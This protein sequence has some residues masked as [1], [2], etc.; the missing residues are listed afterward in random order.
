MNA[1]SS[2]FSVR[3]PRSASSRP[4]LPPRTTRSA[5]PPGGP[6]GSSPAVRLVFG[7]RSQHH[8]R[9]LPCMSK[10]P[11][12]LAHFCP[13]GWVYHPSYHDT[14]HIRP[15]RRIIRQTCNDPLL[16]GRDRQ[17][18]TPP[19][20]ADDTRAPSIRTR[21][22]SRL[23]L[24]ERLQSFLLAQVV[25]KRHRVQPRNAIHRKLGG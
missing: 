3:R 14:R 16:F 6:C 23:E 1:G 19:R 21:H 7:G 8:S 13:T 20:S 10:S 12:A 4:Q 9:T 25:A 15:G 2:L 22:R 5:A 24:V 11:K 18:P 17:I